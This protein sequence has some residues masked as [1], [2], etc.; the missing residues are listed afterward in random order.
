M[1]GFDLVCDV[2]CE[3]GESPVWL[4]ERGELLFIDVRGRRLHRFDTGRG[5]V[6]S[7]AV[8]E[9]IGYVA[10]TRSGAY[11]AGL[12]SGVW[13]LDETGRK[14]R[15]LAKNPGDPATSRFNDGAIDP[16][17]GSSSERSTRAVRAPPASISLDRAAWWSS[18]AES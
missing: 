1:S 3:V 15:C 13:L 17:A 18:P 12:R 4:R 2:V 6:T 16:A 11:V 7:L 14:Q 10:P 8:E 9:D 5:S